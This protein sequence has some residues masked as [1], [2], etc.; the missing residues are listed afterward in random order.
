MT[1]IEQIAELDSRNWI[2]IPEEFTR[3]E[4]EASV[5][6]ARLS[7]NPAV[8]RVAKRLELSLGNTEKDTLGRD[9]IGNINWQESMNT[10]DTL[11][12]SGVSA[13]MASDF[14][15]L[16]SE[17]A[18]GEID[19]YTE[20]GKK[21]DS[22]Y[23]EKVFLDIVEKGSWRGEWFDDTFEKGKNGLYHL[24]DNKRNREKLKGG[25]REYR[26]PGISLD[27]WLNPTEQGLPRE[28]I[29]EGD[30]FY[31][32]PEDGS[33]AGFSVSPDFAALD[34]YGDPLDE[35]AVRAAKKAA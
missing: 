26:I 33:V 4:Y 2:A 20:A 7:C 31:L 27:S 30:L 10:L 6:P 32:A 11:G 1:L 21:L 34:F 25:L 17:G 8:K 15:R 24:T 13:K 5:N 22:K 23:L 18:R 12:V 3:G 29:K 16:L 9:Y 19:V 28:N 14:L 35:G